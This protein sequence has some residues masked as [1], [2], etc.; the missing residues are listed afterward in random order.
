[1]VIRTLC[2]FCSYGCELG[3]V[4]D[5]LGIRGVEYIKD[6]P[7]QGRLCPRGSASVLY[8]NHPKR[9]CVP[10]ENS[11]YTDWGRIKQNL[12]N[13]F[14]QPDAIAVTIDKNVTIDEESAILNFCKKLNLHNVASTYFEPESLLNRLIDEKNSATIDDIEKSQM[15]IVL[16]DIFDNVPMMSRNLI[17]WKLSDRRHRLVV[18]DSVRNH[19]SYFATDFLMVKPGTEAIVMLNLAGENISGIDTSK[20]SDIPD[21]IL[22]DLFKDFKSTETGLIITSMP[23]AHSYEPQVLVEGLKRLSNFSN[24]KILPLFEFVHFNKLPNFGNL[25]PLFKKNRIKYLINFG[26]LFPFYY[27]QIYSELS[28]I[29]VFATSTLRFRDFTQIPIALNMEKSGTILTSFGKKTLRGEISTVSGAKNIIQLLNLLGFETAGSECE[30]PN[31]ENIDFKDGAKRIVDRISQKKD[32]WLMLFGEKISFYYLGLLE[33]P[34]LKINPADAVEIGLK[35]NDF[36]FVESKNNKV[37]I[38]IKITS[39]IPQ[40]AVFTQPETA[41]IRGLFEYEVVNGYLNFNPTGVKIW[42]EE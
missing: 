11:R 17:N 14:A 4:F 41:E 29:N 7:N 20:I 35:P 8:L 18:I 22:Q 33:K 10:V 26:E 15:I 24:K 36:V 5:D 6:T 42:Q 16:G 34:I 27:P 1:M 25:L 9:L 21:K 38:Q 12:Q 40:G 13:A 23:F 2:P 39:E 3:V 19:T 31:N 30:P 37:R 28:G 32:G